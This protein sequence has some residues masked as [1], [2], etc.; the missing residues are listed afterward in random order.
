MNKKTYAVNVE[1]VGTNHTESI[2]KVVTINKSLGAIASMRGAFNASISNTVV[3]LY[4]DT[5]S[6][7]YSLATSIALTAAEFATICSNLDFV[8]DHNHTSVGFRIMGGDRAVYVSI[9]QEE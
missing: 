1:F 2:E 5:Y 6:P 9:D 4:S 3:V 7:T 8:Y